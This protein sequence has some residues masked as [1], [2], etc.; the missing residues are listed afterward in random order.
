MAEIESNK[1]LSE[2]HVDDLTKRGY[3]QSEISAAFSWLLENFPE[4]E[5]RIVVQLPASEGSR[6]TLHDAERMMLTTEAQGY[7]MQLQELGLLDSKELET[8][9]ERAMSTG[10]DRL[11]VAE[12][13]EIVGS[14]LF[15]HSTSWNERRI[16]FNNSETIH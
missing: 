2:I 3:S 5:G 15:S 16:S 11:S 12:V 8:V 14:I 9:I 6:R 1:R 4:H 13:R 7:L 10:F